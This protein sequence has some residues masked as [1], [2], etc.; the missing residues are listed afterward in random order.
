MNLPK[1]V[2]TPMSLHMRLVLHLLN[3]LHGEID[4]PH[5]AYCVCCMRL[6]L[7]QRS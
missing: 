4:V 6:P 1:F 7:L 3:N 5:V 2:I